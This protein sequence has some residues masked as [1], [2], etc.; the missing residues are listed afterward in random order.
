[1]DVCHKNRITKCNNT[2]ARTGNIIDNVHVHSVFIEIMFIFRVIKPR[3]HSAV[4]GVSDSKA[5]GP[6]L[7]TWSGHILSCTLPLIQEGQ[8]SV[9]GKNMCTKYWLTTLGV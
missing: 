3:P 7:D 6:G 8:S 5:R 2:L 4:G 9:P 1:M